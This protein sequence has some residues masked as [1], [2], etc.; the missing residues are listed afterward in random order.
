MDYYYYCY[1]G[2]TQPIRLM[3]RVIITAASVA[4]LY[5]VVALRLAYCLLALRYCVLFLIPESQTFLQP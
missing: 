4:S 1:T 2:L 5:A 3:A